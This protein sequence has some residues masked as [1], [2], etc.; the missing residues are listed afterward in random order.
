MKGFHSS[1]SPSTATNKQLIENGISRSK[2]LSLYRDGQYAEAEVVFL[3]SIQKKIIT[4]GEQSQDVALVRSDLADLYLDMGRLKE[5]QSLLEDAER[6]RRSGIVSDL[7]CTRDNLGRTYE[8]QEEYEQAIKWRT[9]GAPNEMV[10]SH[11]ECP[12]MINA[13]KLSKYVELQHCARCKCV[14]YCNAA[15]QKKDWKRHKKYCKAP[16]PAV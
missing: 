16:G 5:A 14:F 2:A 3:K 12:K 4:N 8:M 10:C 13:A 1:T 15:C 7:A 6:V 9:M 11:L